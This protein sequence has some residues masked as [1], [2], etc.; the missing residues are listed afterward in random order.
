MSGSRVIALLVVPL[1]GLAL[2]G[3][4]QAADA[5]RFKGPVLFCL[6][7]DQSLEAVVS[8]FGSGATQEKLRE[9]ARDFSRFEDRAARERYRVSVE[10]NNARAV[11]FSK[12]ADK[13]LRRGR[14][15]EAEYERRMA[16]YRDAY[17]SYKLAIDRYQAS[18]WFD[19]VEDAPEGVDRKDESIAV[20]G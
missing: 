20:K 13:A 1:C 4:A 9:E 7:G 2:A 3:P 15:D 19:P 18:Y 14:I 5:C 8:R 16:I 6:D 12:D 10:R 11:R 17:A